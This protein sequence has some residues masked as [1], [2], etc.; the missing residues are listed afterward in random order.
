MVA[1]SIGVSQLLDAGSNH[2]T[3]AVQD[4]T[5]DD[6]FAKVLDQ[7]GGT[8]FEADLAMVSG[9][10]LAGNKFDVSSKHVTEIEHT[11]S[12]ISAGDLATVKQSMAKLAGIPSVS[13]GSST[14]QKN[15]TVAA[16]V[17]KKDIALDSS[18][19]LAPKTQVNVSEGATNAIT[20]ASE[21]STDEV[22]DV[23]G[24]SKEELAQEVTAS[25]SQSVSVIEKPLDVMPIVAGDTSTKNIHAGS[26]ATNQDKAE[27]KKT[28]KESAAESVTA[29]T[30]VHATAE[31]PTVAAGNTIL[32]PDALV[33]AS[34]SGQ[35]KAS[36]GADD[37]TESD[38]IAISSHL[39]KSADSKRS[40]VI[41]S[42]V[43]GV[44]RDVSGSGV[45][46]PIEKKAGEKI[47]ATVGAIVAGKA[48]SSDSYATKTS[49]EAT[50]PVIAK[51]MAD[52]TTV[53]ATAQ[54][55]LP[56]G[57]TGL[58]S[59]MV[60]NTA[61]SK[62]HSAVS[63]D[64]S[65][66]I[67]VSGETAMGSSTGAA[68]PHT[69]LGSS[70][71]MLE[72]GVASGTLG[73]LKI[74]AELTAGGDVNASLAG[75]SHL[76]ADKLR[77]ELPALTSYLQEEHVQ[78]STIAVHSTSQAPLV[79]AGVPSASGGSDPFSFGSQGGFSGSMN[80]GTDGGQPHQGTSSGAPQ[81]DIVEA[82]VSNKNEDGIAVALERLP[83][84]AAYGSGMGLGVS[85]RLSPVEYG[86]G[87]SWL[88]V[89]V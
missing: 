58:S 76:I 52:S 44:A 32:P 84:S 31:V 3:Y 80:G 89:R 55:A 9:S 12:E 46:P 33:A 23:V 16:P 6:S 43:P 86:S 63:S 54:I 7:S 1:Q 56:L 60:V 27:V 28:A 81:V 20:S 14:S 36:T 22:L 69:T 51:G 72:V 13:A 78:L 83:D 10:S 61:T 87:G 50:V 65:S 21:P 25:K 41:E 82:G 67:A 73:W 45:E 11:V 8:Q 47:S 24:K 39:S 71:T 59:A 85:G 18:V 70:L 79:A 64:I 68:L 66:T 30:S 17:S 34:V 4:A 62:S 57:P 26:S 15:T 5:S 38:Q 74:R 42:N 88:N 2:S 37:K 77:S 35:T 19:G 29:K 40:T 49:T 48:V 53:S 75:G